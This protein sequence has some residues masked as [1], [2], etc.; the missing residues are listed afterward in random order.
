V[1]CVVCGVCAALLSP[2]DKEPWRMKDKVHP[3]HLACCSKNLQVG[4]P[5]A[6]AG[7]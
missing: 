7:G 3:I 5:A 6:A 4:G 1:T 2:G